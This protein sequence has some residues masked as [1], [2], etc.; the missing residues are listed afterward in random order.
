MQ[1]VIRA[2]RTEPNVLLQAATGAGKTIMFSA[3]VK[4]FVETWEMRVTILAHREQLVRQAADKLLKVWPEGRGEIGIACSSVCTRADLDRHVVIGSPQTLVNRLGDLPEQRLLVVDECHRLPPRGKKSQYATLINRLREYYPDMRML[5]V[6]ATP[7]RLGHGYIYG[8]DCRNP[9]ENWFRSLA[10][11]IGIED[12]QDE[13]FLAPLKGYGCS[14]PDLSGVKTS[15]GEYDLAQLSGVMSESLH[16]GSAVQALKKYGNDRKHIVIFA[17]TIQHAEI[18]QEAFAKAGYKAAV[19]HS[20]MPHADRQ[21]A[22]E[23]FDRGE[24]EVICNVGVLTEGWDCTSVDC[25]VMCRPTKSTALYVQMVGRGLRTAPGKK[26]CLLLDLSGNWQEHGDP[27]HP[28]VK[29]KPKGNKKAK[30]KEGNADPALIQCVNCE[31]LIPAASLTCPFCGAIQKVLCNRL[32]EMEALKTSSS[33]VQ[34]FTVEGVPLFDS[35]F[36]SRNGNHMLRLNLSGTLE[37]GNKMTISEFFDFNGEAS[38]YGQAK[39]RKVW[40]DLTGTL[41]P[42]TLEEAVDR[43]DELRGHIP[44]EIW[45]KKRDKYFHVVRW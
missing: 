6:T 45:V 37:D 7:Y 24:T 10:F 22:L 40:A 23:A 18:L 12:L 3:I 25:M 42:A 17:V 13:G 41:P 43:M 27:A 38:D 9:K 8:S 33:N 1:A 5:G 31:A 28:R 20:K 35:G 21:K 15:S 32:P 11:S 44:P 2:M 26:D 4:K 16:V 39:A 29:W 30:E 34:K 19:V 14:S 36:R